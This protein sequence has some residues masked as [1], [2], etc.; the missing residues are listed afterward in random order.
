[1]NEPHFELD[2]HVHTSAGSPCSVLDV[3]DLA[4]RA[5]ELKLPVVAV[6][7]HG[8]LEGVRALRTE[9]AGTPVRVIAGMEVTTDHGD[10]LVFALEDKLLEVERAVSTGERRFRALRDAGLLSVDD[11]V[12]WAHPWSA[13]ASGAHPPDSFPKEELSEIIACL[14]AVEGVNGVNLPYDHISSY[15]HP[16]ESPNLWACLF[17]GEVGLPVTCG[18][19]AHEISAF[20]MVPSVF[21]RPVASCHDLHK[22]VREGGI[23]DTTDRYFG[24]N[25]RERA[26]R[27]ERPEA[28]FFG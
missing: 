3:G 5:L 13:G 24:P 23:V 27:L 4:S 7:D 16:F 9:L 10:F 25:W 1:M 17:A 11:L 28:G 12:I 2:L 6:T 15:P 21:S 26:A 18:S 8:S 20:W 19:D 14:S 22:A